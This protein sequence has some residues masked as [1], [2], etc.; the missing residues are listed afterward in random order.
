M[1]GLNTHSLRVAKSLIYTSISVSA[2]TSWHF[3]C[4]S[5]VCSDTTKCVCLDWTLIHFKNAQHHK[6]VLELGH[7][8]GVLPS[9]LFLLSSTIPYHSIPE[10][11]FIFPACFT[12]HSSNTLAI[13]IL[14]DNSSFGSSYSS[15]TS[16]QLRTIHESLLLLLAQGVGLLSRQRHPHSFVFSTMSSSMR[17]GSE[18]SPVAYLFEGL[19]PNL[20]R[21]LAGGTSYVST[22][23]V[24][25]FSPRR[26]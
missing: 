9:F 26:S 14:V 22:T 3:V 23:G 5:H 11:P 21:Y 6:L 1:F 12:K 25:L 13:S 2:S 24:M 4:S 16:K 15:T 10:R 20:A 8:K 7:I 17:A 18:K 19:F